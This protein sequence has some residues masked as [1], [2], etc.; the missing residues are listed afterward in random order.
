MI[1]SDLWMF[2]YVI[3]ISPSNPANPARAWPQSIPWHPKAPGLGFKISVFLLGIHQERTDPF[4]GSRYIQ[5]PND[6]EISRASNVLQ[7]PAIQTHR[8]RTLQPGII[9][10]QPDHLV[11]K[12][13]NPGHG[14]LFLISSHV[15][16]FENGDY[17]TTII[18]TFLFPGWP[19]P[20]TSTGSQSRRLAK[21]AAI[22]RLGTVRN[23]D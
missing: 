19:C 8:L 2:H 21:S 14:Q 16:L 23:A 11:S 17:T 18:Q 5:M 13:E 4:P 10:D 15:S 20:S 6:A 22:S 3:S 7:E 12:A 1:I 9:R